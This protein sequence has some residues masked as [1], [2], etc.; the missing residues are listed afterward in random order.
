MRIK[1]LKNVVRS[2]IV[3]V[4]VLAVLLGVLRVSQKSSDS[5]HEK[6]ELSSSVLQRG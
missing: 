5:D 4:I 6:T 2:V 1:K 3:A